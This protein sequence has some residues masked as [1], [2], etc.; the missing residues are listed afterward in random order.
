MLIFTRIYTENTSIKQVANPKK[1]K[2]PQKRV[3]STWLKVI[4]VSANLKTQQTHCLPKS[5]K[6]PSSAK[7][8][9]S[10]LESAGKTCLT[11]PNETYCLNWTTKQKAHRIKRPCPMF[12]ISPNLA[13]SLARWTSLKPPTAFSAKTLKLCKCSKLW[14]V[15]SPRMKV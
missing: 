3:F 10:T 5:K 13:P 6:I 7:N 12:S 15:S 4:W 2:S 8:Q 1:F 11:S 14:K 9:M